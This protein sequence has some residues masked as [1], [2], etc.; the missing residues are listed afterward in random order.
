MKKKRIDAAVKATGAV[1]ILLAIAAS[2]SCNSQDSIS[3]RIDPN[4][5]PDIRLPHPSGDAI[6]ISA[7]SGETGSIGVEL[8]GKLFWAKGEPSGDISTEKTHAWAWEVN[9]RDSLLLRIDVT[10]EGQYRIIL[11]TASG[12]Q[13]RSLIHLNAAPEE[14]FTGVFER[15]VDGHQNNSWKEGIGT[16]LDLHGER[17]DVRLKPTVSAYAPFYIS[18]E[19]YSFFVQGTWPGLFDFCSRYPDHVQAAFEGPSMEIDLFTA[20]GPME[21]IEQ[22]ALETGPSVVPPEWAFGPWRWRDEHR[23]NPEYFDGTKVTAPYNSD[24]VEDVMMMK[25]Y[26]IPCTAHWIDRPWGPGPRGFD[27]YEF[28]RDRFPDPGGM[29]QWLHRNGLQLMMW[30]APFVMGEQ[31]DYAEA[32]GYYLESNVWR[33]SRQVLMDFTNPGAVAWWGEH[34]PGKLARMGIRGFKMDRADGEKLLDS[35]HLFTWKGTSY[36]ENFN[37]Y[38]RQYVRAAYLALQPVLGDNFIL[39]PRAQYTGSARYGGMWA[40]DTNGK[41]EGLRSAVIGMQ[42]CAVMGYPVWG[43]DIGGYWGE[44]NR[45]TCLR[46]LGFGCFSP[47]METGP[48]L[49]RGFWDTG[50]EH[51][52]D[53]ELIATWRLYS[54]IR[55]KIAPYI[56]SLAAQARETGT[57]IVRPLFLEYPGQPDAWKDWQT[58]LLGPDLLVHI[59]WEKGKTSGMVYLPAGETWI[60]AWDLSEEHEGGKYLEV[61][62]P[63]YRT[64]LFIR[65]GSDMELGNLE[66]LYRESLLLAGKT[67]DLSELESLETW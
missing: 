13:T 51:R 7:P 61:E 44:F 31:A 20:P 3:L 8:D 14:Y 40:G 5:F 41:P 11:E 26:D 23:N 53:R 4:G 27:D 47:L 52:P 35:L 58:Y 18:S 28:D 45:E 55:M 15:V 32:H 37:D 22:H 36:R 49:N 38:P 2:F 9:G 56:R 57:P 54:K 50:E 62:A 66:E 29:I 42:R 1:L 59:I 17:M 65:K 67:F 63:L 10:G 21:L 30:I 48:T 39:Y 60:N 43:S 25:F 46:W 33:Q 12:N 34:G 24:L 6:L 16:G 64:P 19:N